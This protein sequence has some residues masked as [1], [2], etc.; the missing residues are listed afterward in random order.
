VRDE[1]LRRRLANNARKFA[2][3]VMDWRIRGAHYRRALRRLVAAPA[4]RR[5]LVVTYRFADPPPGGAE[6]FLV[7]VLRELALS[8]VVTVDVAA[9]DVGKISNKWHFSAD[10]GERVHSGV[11]PTYVKSAFRFPIDAASA[12]DFD[13]CRR[14]FAVWMAESR[15]LGLSLRAE[16]DRPMLLGGWNFP[17]VYAGNAARWCS[18]EG[19]VRVGADAVSLDIAG[20][21]PHRVRIDAE[22]GGKPVSSKTVDRDFSVSIPLNGD[23]IVMLRMDRVFCADDDPRELGLIVHSMT[24][25]SRDGAHDVDLA[26]DVAAVVRGRTPAKWVKALVD[27]TERRAR[28]DDDLF[29]AVRGPHSASLQA[30]LEDNAASYDVVLVQGVPFA[31]SVE[32]ADI[33]VRQGV[34]LVVLPHFHAED[35]YYHWR[36]YYDMFRKAQ[37][38]IAAPAHAKP[39][40][41]DVI[42]APSKVVAGG[43]VDLREY[44]PNDRTRCR[45]AF[46]ACHAGQKPFVLVLGRKA[47]GKNYQLSIDATLA[48]NRDGHRIDLVLIGPDDDGLLV[49]APHVH[50]YGSQSREVVLGALASALCLVNMSESE[51]F[52]IVLLEAWL[53][54]IPVIAERDCVAFAEL[55]VPG[56]NGFLAES[57]DD[58]VRGIECY[59]SSPPTA[60]S[61][62]QAGRGVAEQYAWGRIAKQIE[63]LLVGA[64]TGATIGSPARRVKAAS[65][66]TTAEAMMQRSET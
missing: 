7:N 19:H 28:D 32:A 25:K 16:H 49:N 66:S 23:P 31:T 11:E 59:L 43:G 26:E 14:L 12:D 53:S 29:I 33:V 21:A 13:H 56:E 20:F 62:A 27:I 50:Y 34:P 9:C 54:G 37:C 57:V 6:T 2:I 63:R 42:G 35:R 1:K 39:M 52:G 47:A 64:S 58:I 24:V 10:Y 40:F 4:K 8:A 5:V 44:D 65:A 55:V 38:V 48:V 17:E 46:A 22:Q 45:Q 3:E 51:S 61:H 18:R 41:F 30:W 15:I 36:R 60:Q